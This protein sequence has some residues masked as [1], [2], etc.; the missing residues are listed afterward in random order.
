MSRTDDSRRQFLLRALAT[1]LY[2]EELMLI[3]TLVGRVPPFALFDDS[4]SG[5]VHY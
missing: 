5:P 2:D 3:E 4:Y 1:G